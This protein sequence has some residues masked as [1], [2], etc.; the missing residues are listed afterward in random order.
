LKSYAF[1]Y[2]YYPR[3]VPAVSA[4]AV[5]LAVVDGHVRQLTRTI[6]PGALPPPDDQATSVTFQL[7]L[8]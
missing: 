5:T 1:G 7:D 3:P 4:M 2:Y 6:E 8:P